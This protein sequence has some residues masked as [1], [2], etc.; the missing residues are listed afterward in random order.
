MHTAADA[1]GPVSPSCDWA[2]TDAPQ[3]DG[4]V[5]PAYPRLISGWQP[6]VVVVD[7]GPWDT[8]D[9]MVPGDTVWRA[10]G[11][12][13][14]DA[15]LLDEMTAATDLLAA[16]GARVVWLT[17][18]PWEGATRNPPPSVYGPAADPARMQRY[19]DL[20]RQ[21]AARRPGTVRVIDLAG[22]LAATGEDAR[23]RP[24]GAHFEDATALEVVRRY[25]GD[26]LV[27][28]AT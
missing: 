23:L 20:V 19:N 14:Y 3:M 8:A 28:V 6:N 22:W 9:R 4:S 25:L 17:Q 26:E 15:W 2:S 5:R 16:G 11:D 10:V 12:P 1:I 24:D 7:A 18:P 21:L 27:R 13:V